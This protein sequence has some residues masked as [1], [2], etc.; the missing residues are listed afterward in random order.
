MITL[1]PDETAL[2]LLHR[3]SLV[4]SFQVRTGGS[5]SEQIGFNEC[6]EVITS[7]EE[8]SEV[9]KCFID[10]NTFHVHKV[11]YSLF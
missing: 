7:V 11:D 1:S 6:V 10:N 8:M 4:K 5:S 2:E 9:S 3:L